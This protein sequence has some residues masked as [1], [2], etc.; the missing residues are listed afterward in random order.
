MLLC[1]STQSPPAWLI[2]PATGEVFEGKDDCY[3]R[4]QGW[5]L[6]EDF[7]VVQGRKVVEGWESSLGVQV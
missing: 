4:L 2:A 3:Q 7:G 5:G 6:F 1:P